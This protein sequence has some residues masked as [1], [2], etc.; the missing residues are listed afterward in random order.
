MSHVVGHT[1][2]EYITLVPDYLAFR[3]YE[4]ASYAEWRCL[5]CQTANKQELNG[6]SQFPIV[7]CEGCGRDYLLSVQTYQRRKLPG[8]E[9]IHAYNMPAKEG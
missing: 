7:F 3:S 1:K 8:A 5:I 9:Q 4:I 2:P 6:K